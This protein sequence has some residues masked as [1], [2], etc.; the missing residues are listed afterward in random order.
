MVLQWYFSLKPLE[1]VHFLI[2]LGEKPRGNEIRKGDI[3]TTHTETAVLHFNGHDKEYSEIITRCAADNMASES[4]HCLAVY[5]LQDSL[6][7]F[8][9]R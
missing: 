2:T 7:L 9:S 3:L 5:L 8:H 4:R 6:K 1:F